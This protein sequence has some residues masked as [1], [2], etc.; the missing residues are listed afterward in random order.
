MYYRN[1][2][3]IKKETVVAKNFDKMKNQKCS[4]KKMYNTSSKNTTNKNV[5]E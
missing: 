3:Q 4:Y 5:E 1:V 2:N